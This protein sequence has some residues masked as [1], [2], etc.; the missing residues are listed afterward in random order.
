MMSEKTIAE[1][2]LIKGDYKVLFI[3]PPEGYISQ[4]GSLAEGVTVLKNPVSPVN[5]I[6]LFVTSRKELQAHLPGLKNR[7][8]PGGLLWVTYPKGTS[9]V[10]ADINRDSINAY[11]KS[12]GLIG[13]AMISI[14]DTWSALRL[15]PV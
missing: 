9:K 3:N 6:Q 13:V 11:A 2:L 1:K 10:K 7:L 5:L 14:D 12:L 4:L 8:A 15:K